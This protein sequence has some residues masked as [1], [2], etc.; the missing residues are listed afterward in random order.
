M[1]RRRTR[2]LAKSRTGPGR[3]SGAVEQPHGKIQNRAPGLATDRHCAAGSAAGTD[4]SGLTFD[5]EVVTINI[6]R[7]GASLQGVH[8]KLQ[9]GDK[10]TLARLG[11]QEPFRVEWMVPKKTDSASQ[12]GVSAVDS[13]TSFWDDVLE[14]QPQLAGG[15]TERNYSEKAPKPKARAHGA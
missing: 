4:A 11:K 9:V 12:V 15:S 13:N 8:G 6:S 7:Q 10:V 5:Q 3:H 14:A 2:R 1:A